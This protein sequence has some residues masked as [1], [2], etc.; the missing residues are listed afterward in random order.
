MAGPPGLVLAEHEAAADRVVGPAD[1]L[2]AVVTVGS[3]PH[4][5]GVKVQPLAPV[6]DHIVVGRERDGRAAEEAEAAGL[7]DRGHRG[8]GRRRVNRLRLLAGQA[9]DDR[10]TLPCPCPVAPSEPNSSA[11]TRRT[12]GSS[13]SLSS[14]QAKEYAARIGPTVCEL[15]GP[16]PILNKSNTLIVIDPPLPQSLSV[17]R[18]RDRRLR[19]R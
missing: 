3:K 15:D 6:Q 11:C 1:Q 2:G 18:G 16:M 7:A 19:D 17:P 9:E 13:P 14:E 12:S 8:L 5:V 10:L 4:A